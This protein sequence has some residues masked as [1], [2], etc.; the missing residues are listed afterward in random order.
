MT[1]QL[2]YS[3]QETWFWHSGGMDRPDGAGYRRICI[4]I[5]LIHIEGGGGKDRKGC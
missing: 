3:T 1:D 5:E 2:K 4:Y